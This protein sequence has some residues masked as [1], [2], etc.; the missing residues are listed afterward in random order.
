MSR[1]NPR[2]WLRDFLPSDLQKLGHKVRILTFGYDS[3]LNNNSGAT[4]SIQSHARMLLDNLSSQ[5]RGEK[6][7]VRGQSWRTSIS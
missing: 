4:P 5:R 2:M 3:A 7:Y 1:D 6:V